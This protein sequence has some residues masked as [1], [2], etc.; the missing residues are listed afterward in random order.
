[1][2]T[3]SDVNYLYVAV[4][5]QCVQD[6]K[7]DSD[8]GEMFMAMYACKDEINPTASAYL[9]QT[10]GRCVDNMSASSHQFIYMNLLGAIWAHS[11]LCS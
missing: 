4:D 2:C 6:D 3:E 7:F 5:L 8:D 10:F 9:P 1:M 11:S